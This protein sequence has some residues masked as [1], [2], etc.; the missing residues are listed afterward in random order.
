MTSP[1]PL[2]HNLNRRDGLACRER[3]VTRVVDEGRSD[4]RILPVLPRTVDVGVENGH[5]C[6]RVTEDLVEENRPFRVCRMPTA[7]LHRGD[8]VGVSADPRS[9]VQVFEFGSEIQVRGAIELLNNVRSSG[10]T[11]W[12]KIST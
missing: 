7:R 11:I 8:G 9:G 2:I 5:V 6:R 4:E 3:A 1:H 10:R 12:L